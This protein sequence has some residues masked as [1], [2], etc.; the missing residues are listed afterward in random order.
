MNE[1][2][3]RGAAPATSDAGGDNGGDNGGGDPRRIEHAMCREFAASVAH[4]LNNTILPVLL[5]AEL[6]RDD[7]PTGEKLRTHMEKILSAAE[8]SRAYLDRVGEFGRS[9]DLERRSVA[10]AAVF[11]K[12]VERLRS[13]LPP[14]VRLQVE[15]T[16]GDGRMSADVAKIGD[17]VVELGTNAIEAFDGAAGS[18]EF[19]AS[20]M[21]IEAG[22]TT[23]PQGLAAG[24]YA[25]FLVRDDGPGMSPEAVRNAFGPF[26]TGKAGRDARG[27]GLAIAYGIV[28]GHAGAIVLG[29]AVGEGTRA[30]MYL[31]MID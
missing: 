2:S 3:T 31:P 13:V 25:K 30:E 27:L 22:D 12:A 6:T 5:L 16:G 20:E 9:W 21:R 29:G 11:D 1:P 8:R 10:L 28:S 7:L 19:Q 24:R 14:A 15:I 18:I 4:D 26:V 17:V 23:A